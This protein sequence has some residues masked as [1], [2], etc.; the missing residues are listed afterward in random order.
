MIRVGV[1]VDADDSIGGVS[2][3]VTDLASLDLDCLE[4]VVIALEQGNAPPWAV[5]LE[6]AGRARVLR[7]TRRGDPDI[8]NDPESLS[9]DESSIRHAVALIDGKVDVL[10]PNHLEFGYRIGAAMLAM[11]LEVRIVGI[12]HTDEPYY[13]HLACK[14]AEILNAAVAVC[15]RIAQ[16]LGRRCQALRAMTRVIPCGVRMEA[17][18]RLE[19]DSG[20]E[21]LYVGRL[22]ERQKRTL[23]LVELARKL[24]ERG[25]QAQ[26]TII[27]DGDNR[28]LLDRGL[29]RLGIRYTLTGSLAREMVHRRM[30]S[31]AVF[32]LVS[33]T[34]GFPISIIEAMSSGMVVVAPR[35][36]GI[37]EQVTHGKTGLLYPRGEM[38]AAADCILSLERTPTIRHALG[39]A[40][41][42]VALRRWTLERHAQQLVACLVEAVARPVAS[43][44]AARCTLDRRSRM[45]WSTGA[46]VF[47]DV[48]RHG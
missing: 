47:E 28:Q 33:D 4:L 5:K 30:R 27:G 46:D 8:D 11:G 19:S 48:S 40:A 44:D 31:A 43:R 25:S 9:P 37:P 21:V 45:Q 23:R 36:A 13:Y 20:F 1:F 7:I 29:A 17:G 16:Q 18:A 12:C 42:D 32:V 3:W 10:I 38:D 24:G 41:A 26:L 6:L 2:S 35:V 14:Y 39:T 34:E 15:H 22:V